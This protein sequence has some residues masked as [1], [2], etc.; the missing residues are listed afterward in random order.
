LKLI[1]DPF[2]NKTCPEAQNCD[3]QF[4]TLNFKKLNTQSLAILLSFP[5]FENDIK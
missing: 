1:F 4:V 3:L 5:L 2:V